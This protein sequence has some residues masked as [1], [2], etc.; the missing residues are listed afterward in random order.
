MYLQNKYTRWYYDIIQRA[1]LRKLPPDV[2]TEKHHII[3][4]SL[5]GDN[6]KENIIKLTAKEHFICHMLLVKMTDGK[7]KRS[8]AY[9]AWQ[10]TNIDSRQRYS[11]T[12]R[13][14]SLLKKNLSEAYKGV[15]KTKIHWLGKTHSAQTKILQ[16][17]IKKNSNN[18]MW[19]KN[20]KKNQKKL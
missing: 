6:Q 15:P 13:I 16:S 18:P 10:M 8:M 5:G 19:G 3:P 9:A 2:Y 11:P 12:S 4:R 7:S 1:Q 17:T 14:Y 20:T